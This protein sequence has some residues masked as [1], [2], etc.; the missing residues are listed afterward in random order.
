MGFVLVGTLVIERAM[1]VQ[2]RDGLYEAVGGQK[3]AQGVVVVRAQWPTRFARNGPFFDRDVLYL[4]APA[5][6]SVDAIAEKYPSRPIYEAIEGAPWKII[7]R[8]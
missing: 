3:I 7:R 1:L 4:S 5:S 6:T 8:R 2:A